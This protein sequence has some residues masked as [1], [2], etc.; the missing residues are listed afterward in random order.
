MT[1]FFVTEGD[2]NAFFFYT[3]FLYIIQYNLVT[4]NIISTKDDAMTKILVIESSPR[5]EGSVTRKV[6]KTIIDKLKAEYAGATVIERDL[7]AN[8][9]PH[10]HENQ[11]AAFYTPAEQRSDVL[12]DATKS[13]DAAV[14]ELLAADIIV[15]GAPMWNFNIPSS[16]KAWIDHVVR[17]GRTFN[18]G[19][20]GPE[21]LL[22]GKK[23]IVAVASG[24]VYSQGPA[25]VMDFET[26]YLRGILGFIGITDVSFVRAEGVGMGEDAVKAAL[27]A[28]DKQAAEA[29]KKA[30]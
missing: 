17:K 5:G 28:A 25:Q 18:Y 9:L 19:A 7:A 14:D 8:P 6:A 15:I 29:V 13:S 2:E 20:A 11:I 27:A 24:G 10:L 1:Y 23:V 12:K 4:I 22:K 30:A 16:L 21:G 3:K 26:V